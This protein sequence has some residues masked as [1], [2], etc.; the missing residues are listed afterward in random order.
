MKMYAIADTRNACHI[1]LECATEEE[2]DL[3]AR[4]EEGFV[5]L[6]QE[7]LYKYEFT[8]FDHQS[9][10]TPNPPSCDRCLKEID[11]NYIRDHLF[12]SAEDIV[13]SGIWPLDR[14]TKEFY[15]SSSDHFEHICADWQEKP[16]PPFDAKAQREHDKKMLLLGRDNCVTCAHYYH[17]QLKAEEYEQELKE[18]RHKGD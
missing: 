4:G 12:Q 7:E 14:G 2:K 3:A 10:D 18:H 11:Y 17:C 15:E 6:T 5:V 1:C 8:D 9:T 16:V 13:N